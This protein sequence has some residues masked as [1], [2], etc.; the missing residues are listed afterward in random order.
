MQ[1]VNAVGMTRMS[2]G[3]TCLLCTN[4]CN[5]AFFLFSIN[6]IE[7]LLQLFREQIVSSTTL[8]VRPSDLLIDINYKALPYPMSDLHNVICT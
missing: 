3:G 8:A 4:I 2:G 7:W 6:A 1:E 5:K